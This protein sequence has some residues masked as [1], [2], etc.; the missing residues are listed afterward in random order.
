M[1][2]PATAAVPAAA[3]EAPAAAAAAPSA[4]AAPAETPQ[5]ERAAA[6]EGGDDAASETTGSANPALDQEEEEGE[7]KA[8]PGDD[9]DAAASSDDLVDWVRSR[10]ILSG[11]EPSMWSEEHD[12]VMLHFLSH[13]STQRLFAYV[14][15]DGTLQLSTGGVG[16]GGSS[17][18]TELMYFIRPADEALTLASVSERVKYGRVGGKCNP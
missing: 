10:V 12:A 7:A 9:G 3:A 17:Q 5:P 13:P 6:E 15:D 1:S 2:D 8:G 14:A 16:G 11:L 4:A 18:S